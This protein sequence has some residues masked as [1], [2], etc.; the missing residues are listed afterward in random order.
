V[1]GLVNTF[2]K[3]ILERGEYGGREGK[4]AADRGS[5]GA[6]A[7]EKSGRFLDR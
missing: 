7:K 5:I 6:A 3:N 2:L 4:G 1:G